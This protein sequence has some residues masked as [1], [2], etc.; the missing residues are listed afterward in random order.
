MVQKTETSAKIEIGTEIE[1]G[2]EKIEIREGG[3]ATQG[4]TNENVSDSQFYFLFL[5]G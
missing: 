4:K 2:N 1:I 5:K 3:E